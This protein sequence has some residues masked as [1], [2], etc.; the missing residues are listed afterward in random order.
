[1][2]HFRYLNLYFRYHFQVLP[3]AIIL[4]KGYLGIILKYGWKKVSI[5]TQN[6]NLYTIVSEAEHYS[7]AKLPLLIYSKCTFVDDEYFE[8]RFDRKWSAIH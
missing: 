1:M 2:N 3:N 5:I 7:I 4:A 6:E 8:K